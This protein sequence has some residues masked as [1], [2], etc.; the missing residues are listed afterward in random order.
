MSES[1]IELRRRIARLVQAY[2]GLHMREIAR[3]AGISEA[4]AGYHLDELVKDE[5]LE[6]VQEEFFRRFYPAKGG[7][8]EEDRDLLGALRQ[9]VPLQIVLHLLGHGQATQQQLA[10]LVGVGK[11]T[12]SYHVGRLLD[13]DLLATPAEGRGVVLRDPKRVERLLLRYQPPKDLT[14]RMVDLWATFYGPRRRPSKD[15]A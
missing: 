12:M 2:P 9:R 6:S 3:Q 15:A 5:V 13:L 11:S 1:S 4:L 8:R 10:D 14:D 7:A